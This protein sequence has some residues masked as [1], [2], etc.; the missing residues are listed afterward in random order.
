VADTETAETWKASF[1][2]EQPLELVR[3]LSPPELA[4]LTARRVAGNSLRTNL[5]PPEYSARYR[6]Q[7]IDR[8]WMRGLGA[9]LVVYVMAA[10]LYLG[11]AQFAK[12][13]CSRVDNELGKIGPTY[14]NTLQLKEQVKILQDQVDLQY[15]A[16]DCWKAVADNMPPELTLESLS[17]DRGRR[18]TLTGSAANDGVGKV[19]EFNEFIA[20]SKT[21]DR[22]LFK[23]VDAPSMGNRPG[24]QDQITWRFVSELKLAETE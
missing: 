18:L 9:L 3:S 24:V 20:K 23:H 8:L 10:A 1:P 6:Q 4:A 22:D 5:L 21:K 17:F 16:L 19:Q 14:T 2:P 13:R 15:A 11:W 7:F 12:W